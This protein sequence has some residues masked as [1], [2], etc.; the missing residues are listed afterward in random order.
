[1]P[2]WYILKSAINSN[3]LETSNKFYETGKFTDVDP[4]FMFNF[5]LSLSQIIVPLSLILIGNGD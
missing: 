2:I 4:A 3:G 5:N 1:M